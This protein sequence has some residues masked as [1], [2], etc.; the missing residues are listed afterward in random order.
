MGNIVVDS[1]RSKNIFGSYTIRDGYIAGT[2]LRIYSP[3]NDRMAFIPCEAST[4]YTISRSVI[5]SSFRVSDYTAIPPQTTASAYFTIPTVV[6]NNTGT[7]MTYT[8]SSS[9]KYLIIHYGNV[10]NDS[11]TTLANSLASIQV[12]KGNTKTTFAPYQNLGNDISTGSAILDLSTDAVEINTYAK[13]GK[14]AS[15][16]IILTLTNQVSVNATT[17]IAHD[18]PKPNSIFGNNG[19]EFFGVSKSD[20]SNIRCRIDEGGKLTFWYLNNQIPAGTQIYLFT[21]YITD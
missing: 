4:T 2:Q 5:T 16:K 3:A 14:I 18:L 1:I 15:V 11:A 13:C 8:T 7:E 21:T 6:E 20:K 10:S 17:Q 12:E 9:A 19:W